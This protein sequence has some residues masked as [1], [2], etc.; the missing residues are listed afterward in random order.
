MIYIINKQ[1]N[2][3]L[4][5]LIQ[6]KEAYKP[7][8]FKIVDQGNLSLHSSV[9]QINSIFNLSQQPNTLV[10]LFFET[11]SNRYLYVI[12]LAVLFITMAKSNRIE[13]GI[14]YLFS[15]YIMWAFVPITFA[16]TTILLL[17]PLA[18]L[19]VKGNFENLLNYK[20]ENNKINYKNIMLISTIV[21]TLVPGVIYIN[22]NNFKFSLVTILWTVTFISHLFAKQK[23]ITYKM[24]EK[25]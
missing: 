23:L 1:G 18:N 14:K 12:I 15:I 24:V 19:I 17:A 3:F 9:E 16:Y 7:Y 8:D 13:L 10:N 21:I 5:T 20:S 4:K 25:S 11:T 2:P 22:E 6:M